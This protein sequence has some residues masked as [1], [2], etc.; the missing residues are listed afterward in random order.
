MSG[1]EVA[2]LSA[3]LARVE[4]K[5]EEVASDVKD[6]IAWQNRIRGAIA[7]LSFI[8]VTEGL[9]ILRSVLGG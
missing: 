1:E 3:I 4:K 6:V 8:G 5:L 7:I 9:I 2:T